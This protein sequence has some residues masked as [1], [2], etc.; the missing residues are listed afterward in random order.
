MAITNTYGKF[1]KAKFSE[2]INNG[3]TI[4]PGINKSFYV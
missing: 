3:I 4:I 1:L 2:I